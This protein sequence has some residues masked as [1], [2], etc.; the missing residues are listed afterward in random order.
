M[1]RL[2]GEFFVLRGGFEFGEDR[3][4]KLFLDRRG[5]GTIGGVADPFTA[6]ILHCR[7]HGF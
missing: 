1:N 4:F 5:F 7:F 2:E 6:Q 3:R